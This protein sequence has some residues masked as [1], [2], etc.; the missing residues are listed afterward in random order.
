M[1]IIALIDD[2]DV[3]ECIL[4]H[5]KVW[6]PIPDPI[7]PAGADPPWP[8]G[9]TL[10]LSYHPVPD[11][12]CAPVWTPALGSVTPKTA[13]FMS[14]SNDCA[15]VTYKP[16]LLWMRRS[17]F[18]LHSASPRGF[19]SI[20]TRTWSRRRNRIS[21]YDGLT[22]VNALVVDSS[23]PS[24]HSPVI[25]G[26]GWAARRPQYTSPQRLHQICANRGLANY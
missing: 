18:P 10:P 2:A 22:F 15:R 20:S 13:E 12:A 11:I 24:R 16:F 9:E 4:T 5:L 6:D 7:S 19:A 17:R 26:T 1:R 21:F 23:R 14:P 25:M 8:D 3:V